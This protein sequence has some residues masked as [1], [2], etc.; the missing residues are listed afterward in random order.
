MGCFRNALCSEWYQ[1]LLINQRIIIAFLCT[2][3][4][5][6]DPRDLGSCEKCWSGI[7]IDTESYLPHRVNGCSVVQFSQMNALTWIWLPK[8]SVEEVRNYNVFILCSFLLDDV[9]NS[10]II[11]LIICSWSI[12]VETIFEYSEQREC[13]FLHVVSMRIFWDFFRHVKCVRNNS[14]ISEWKL[15][16]RNKV[17]GPFPDTQ[18]I[19]SEDNFL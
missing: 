17:V 6:N 14:I 12:S 1:M 18:I 13:L 11:F 4:V 15:L 19:H 8:I 2:L 16:F 9:W 3:I 5:G 7:H 10:V